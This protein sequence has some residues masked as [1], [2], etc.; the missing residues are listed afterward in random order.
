MKTKEFSVNW[1]LGDSDVEVLDG[2]EGKGE[3]RFNTKHLSRVCKA[4]LCTEFIKVQQVRM[5][6]YKMVIL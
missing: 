1:C 3:Q 2:T 5:N 6:L 4:K